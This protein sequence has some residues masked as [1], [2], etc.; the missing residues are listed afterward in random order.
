MKARQEKGGCGG[1]RFGCCPAT[2]TAKADDDGSN[3]EVMKARQEK[4]GCGG[5]R[6]GC[7]PATQTAKADDDG[8]NCEV[9]KARQ[10]KAAVVVHGSAAALRHRR[11]RP[12]TMGAIV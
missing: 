5:T 10:E 6:F 12:M 4:G 7:C 1:T 9:M 3:C 11:Q 2:Q 8:S